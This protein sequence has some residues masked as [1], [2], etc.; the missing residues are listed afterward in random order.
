M[1]KQLDKKAKRLGKYLFSKLET[2]K[3][4][5]VVREVRGKGLFFG[6]GAG[7][8]YKDERTLS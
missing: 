8:G 3:Q 5:G 1:E 4:Y 6:C 2:L 7:K